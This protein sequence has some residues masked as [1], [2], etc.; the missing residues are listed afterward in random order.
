MMQLVERNPQPLKLP[1]HDLRRRPSVHES[2]AFPKAQEIYETVERP[3]SE[4][5]VLQRLSA[6]MSY[7]P[8]HER[9]SLNQLVRG[10]SRCVRS[11]IFEEPEV[12]SAKIRL[13]VFRGPVAAPSAPVGLGT[14]RREYTQLL[15]ESCVL[16][17]RIADTLAAHSPLTGR[18][19]YVDSVRDAMER[20][21]RD[22]LLRRALAVFRETF[23]HEQR[24]FAFG[25]SLKALLEKELRRYP[26]ESHQL[27]LTSTRGDFWSR[28]DQDLL[29]YVDRPTEEAR[30]RLHQLYFDGD[31]AR[32]A[33]EVERVR[34]LPS[35]AAQERR[36]AHVLR[37]ERLACA[38]IQKGYARLGGLR[39]L[40]PGGPGDARSN[41]ETIDDLLWIDNV[42]E[43]YIDHKHLLHHEFFLRLHLARLAVGC[44][45]ATW[46]IAP[47]QVTDDMIRDAARVLFGRDSDES[48]GDGLGQWLGPEAIV[49]T[50]SDTAIARRL[51]AWLDETPLDHTPIDHAA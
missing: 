30:T 14:F 13:G 21:D 5:A 19:T 37:R 28:Y 50:R 32:F 23:V 18:R 26:A 25:S 51:G 16:Q 49:F 9:R 1:R 6:P 43:K 7:L 40:H 33:R 8:A 10:A 20:P 35:D 4:E 12:Q 11:W 38:R 24:R 27:L 17:R 39:L 45:L 46:G 42:L 22:T 47:H 44:Y 41:I 34:A 29:A 48:T 36:R 3:Q 2:P 31:H 15:A